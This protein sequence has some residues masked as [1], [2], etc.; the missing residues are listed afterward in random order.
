MG[1]WEGVYVCVYIYICMC[2]CMCVGV[3]YVCIYI[4]IRYILRDIG[5][6]QDN[7]CCGKRH[8]VCLKAGGASSVAFD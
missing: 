8:E 3:V 7:D 2:V 6:P 4:Y 5:E 1:V